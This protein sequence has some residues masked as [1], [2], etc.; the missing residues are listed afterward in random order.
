MNQSKEAK[1]IVS[2]TIGSPD[3]ERAVV[4]LNAKPLTDADC[5]RI[6]TDKKSGKN[7]E[8]EELRKPSTTSAKATPR[9]TDSA[10]PSRT[11]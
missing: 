3:A 2:A 10:A 1:V 11:W 4:S 9:S 6:F 7:A 8:R 5:T